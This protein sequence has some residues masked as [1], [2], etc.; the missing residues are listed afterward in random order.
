MTPAATLPDPACAPTP[1]AASP[2][3][4]AHD[5]YFVQ[6]LWV[7]DEL[8]GRSRHD[9]FRE[10]CANRRVLHVGCVDWPITSVESSLHL[11]LD[12]HC[13]A[14]DGFDVHDEAFA[15]LQPHLRV[16]LPVGAPGRVHQQRDGRR[17]MSRCSGRCWRSIPAGRGSRACSRCGRFCARPV[18]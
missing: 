15:M 11:F 1:R 13:A 12:R 17:S 4:A 5:P 14:L 16:P 3:E 9:V 7:G 8:V 2:L 6:K 18:R 10:I